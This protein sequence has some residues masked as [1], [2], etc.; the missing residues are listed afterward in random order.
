M[1]E[2]Q[3][4]ATSAFL[5]CIICFLISKL[6]HHK[7]DLPFLLAFVSIGLAT[8]MDKD[9]LSSKLWDKPPWKDDT[10]SL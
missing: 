1:L 8:K 4:L 10:Q 2:A 7:L 9:P 6:P 5:D 3:D